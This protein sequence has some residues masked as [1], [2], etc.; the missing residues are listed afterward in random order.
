[1]SDTTKSGYA[2]FAN[3]DFRLFGTAR[4]LTGLAYQMQAVAIGWFVYDL[5]RS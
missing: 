3:G 4:F 5:T 2:V 1:M